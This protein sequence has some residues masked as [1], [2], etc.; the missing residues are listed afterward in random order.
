MAAAGRPVS[1]K[2]TGNSKKPK[3]R[4]KAAV[5]PAG[6]V[7]KDELESAGDSAAETGPVKQIAARKLPQVA[8]ASHC[9]V[10]GDGVHHATI[11]KQQSFTIIAKT[12]L[13]EQLSI[14]GT[15]FKVAIRGGSTNSSSSA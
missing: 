7:V 6:A 15:A 10:S 13:D 1:L 14:G 9:T 2:K 8:S 3:R 11:R 4:A 5:D 12:E